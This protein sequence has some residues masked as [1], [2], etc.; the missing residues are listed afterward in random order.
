MAGKTSEEGPDGAGG[1]APGR[2]YDWWSRHPRALDAVYALAFLGREGR[3]R[4]RSL[5]R[6]DLER[7]ERVLE[8]GC[9]RGNSF[10]GLREGVGAD[11]RVVGVDVSA[12]MVAAAT[13]R[14][15]QRG[16]ANVAAIRGDAQRLPVSEGSFDA[17]YASMSM[18]AVPDPERAV[19]TVHRALC[20]GGRFVVLD[21]QPF[22]EWPWRAL[23]PVVTPLAERATNWVPEVDV[24]GALRRTFADTDVVTFDG[25]SIYVACA[26]KRV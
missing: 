6:L 13:R 26:R 4:G 7:G 16:W 8:V 2:L 24:P 9:G 14:I 3:F 18:S 15:T 17:A 11:G 25:G 12:G 21:A 1:T 5:D 22:Q 23:N 10:D 19:E 20:P